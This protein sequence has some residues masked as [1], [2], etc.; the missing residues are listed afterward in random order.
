VSSHVCTEEHQMSELMDLRAQM[1]RLGVS[2]HVHEPA[3]GPCAATE[4]CIT[5]EEPFSSLVKAPS[6]TSEVHV[7]TMTAFGV[8][9]CLPD[10]AGFDATWKELVDIDRGA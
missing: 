4:T 7:D 3:G 1:E 5:E 9:S 6:R 2:A 8:L 10:G